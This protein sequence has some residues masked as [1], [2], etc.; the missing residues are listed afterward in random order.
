MR[1]TTRCGRSP[2][3]PRAACCGRSLTE[4]HSPTEGLPWCPGDCFLD[5]ETCGRCTRRGRETRAE[6]V[7]DAAGSGDA[8]RAG[9]GRGGVGCSCQ[10]R[11]PLAQGQWGA[12]WLFLFGRHRP[13]VGGAPVW[14]LPHA[15]PCV[16]IL[17]ATDPASV[18]P[19]FGN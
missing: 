16:C 12:W 11:L 15:T 5:C 1:R 3:E 2:T 14:Q 7:V 6:R 19:R 9:G 10:T 4:P 8:R 13:C 18:E 17:A